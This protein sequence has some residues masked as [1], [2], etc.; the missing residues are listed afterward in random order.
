MAVGHLERESGSEYGGVRV[1]RVWAAFVQGVKIK[2]RSA[3]RG[4]L[5]H[6]GIRVEFEDAEFH[7]LPVV[8]STSLPYI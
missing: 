7:V 2:A 6:L 8:G 1:A 5:G 3:I 4:V